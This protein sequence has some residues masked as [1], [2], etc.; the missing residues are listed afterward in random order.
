MH[1]ILYS[2]LLMTRFLRSATLSCLCKYVMS[3]VAG[4]MPWITWG[5]GYYA[6]VYDIQWSLVITWL[7]YHNA[8]YYHTNVYHYQTIKN[9]T[10]YIDSLDILKIPHILGDCV[11]T[12]GSRF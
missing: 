5:T 11:R 12:V 6:Y 2:L 8:G 9:W 3:F 10:G 1:I 4:S 7:L